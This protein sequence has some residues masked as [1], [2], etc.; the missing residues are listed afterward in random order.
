MFPVR[1]FF[2]DPDVYGHMGF[3]VKCVSRYWELT[4]RRTD[5]DHRRKK[6]RVFYQDILSHLRMG[7]ESEER[8]QQVVYCR[9]GDENGGLGIQER[10]QSE[11]L[12]F[13]YLLS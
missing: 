10:R 4:L 3:Q 7:T 11:D 2:T 12:K 9:A 13:S 6:S 8:P 5:E 1:K